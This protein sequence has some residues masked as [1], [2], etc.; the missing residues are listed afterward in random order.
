M[1]WFITRFHAAAE[2]I[3]AT[4]SQTCIASTGCS[5]SPPCA[6]GASIANS[7]AWYM[8]S[9]TTSD[10]CRFASA[11]FGVFLDDRPDF[12]DRLQKSLGHGALLT[13]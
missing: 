8:A 10:S 1:A 5:S 11:R 3:R 12:F 4:A 6:F 9:Y 7:P 13:V 2:S